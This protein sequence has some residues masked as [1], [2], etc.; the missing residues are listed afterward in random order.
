MHRSYSIDRNF[1][2]ELT[3]SGEYPALKLNGAGNSF[4]VLPFAEYDLECQCSRSYLDLA[5]KLC[6]VNFGIGADGL[7]LVAVEPKADSGFSVE[8]INRDGSLMGMCGNGL[9]CVVAALRYWGIVDLGELA[10]KLRSGSFRCLIRQRDD[11]EGGDEIATFLGPCSFDRRAV[12]FTHSAPELL[13]YEYLLPEAFKNEL[14]VD[15]FK[16]S[17]VSFGNPHCVIFLDSL[18]SQDQPLNISL[19]GPDQLRGADQIV[20]KIGAYFQ[21]CELFP[22]RVNVEFVEYLSED[23]VK[24]RVWERG[25]GETLACGSGACAVFAVISKLKKQRDPIYIEMPGG[26]LVLSWSGELVQIVGPV[27]I[28]SEL[29]LL[30]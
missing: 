19:R 23:R 28:V 1:K 9:R 29:K 14:G 22:D 3:L 12:L 24:V 25:V 8:L 2:T 16:I 26:E 17:C 11:V 30:V 7:I 20:A 13:D 18:I 21:T 15:R 10:L 4:V 27:Q 5:Q 6:D